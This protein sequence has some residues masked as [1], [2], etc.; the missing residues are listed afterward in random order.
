MA[1]TSSFVL[2]VGA[3]VAERDD[4]FL[5]TLAKDYSLPLE[6]LRTKY[7]AVAEA[8]IKVPKKYKPRQPKSVTVTEGGEAAP[9]VVKAP[10]APKAPKAQKLDCTAHTSKKEPC[11]FG[12]LKGEVFC[13]R[14]LRQANGDGP[15]G[16]APPAKAAKKGPQPVHTHPL[17]HSTHADCETCQTYGNP[18]DRAEQSFEV[19]IDL[20]KPE[21]E[22]ESNIAP[23]KVYPTAGP[24]KVVKEDTVAARLAAILD[25]AAS[26]EE[27]EEDELMDEEEFE[28][29]D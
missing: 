10:K 15:D 29:E 23:E 13:K 25:A 26:D 7:A 24:I 11:K 20:T 12:A 3:L 14:H 16:A 5:Q 27:E 17:D 18:L 1:T 21:S 6:E 2:A 28:E 19:V 4:Q 22:S 8:A 9:P